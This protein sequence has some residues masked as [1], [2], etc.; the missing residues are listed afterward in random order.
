MTK[1]G[2]YIISSE[3]T[4]YNSYGN[5]E[6]IVWKEIQSA[7][8][9]PIKWWIRHS[10]K[11]KVIMWNI[12]PKIGPSGATYKIWFMLFFSFLGGILDCKGVLVELIQCLGRSRT[13][14]TLPGMRLPLFGMKILHK[15][16]TAFMCP[17]IWTLDLHE[18]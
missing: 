15:F 10:R 12:I 3:N 1:L 5:W 17:K 16:E 8:C 11:Q 9:V 4:S 13:D 6:I 14:C 7:S 2:N 18:E